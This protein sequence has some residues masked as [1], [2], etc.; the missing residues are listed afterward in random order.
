MNYRFVTIMMCISL[1]SACSAKSSPVHGLSELKQKYPSITKELDDVSPEQLDRLLL[2]DYIPFEV[3]EVDALTT[4]S[5]EETMI[6]LVYSNGDQNVHIMKLDDVATYRQRE[7][8]QVELSNGTRAK[9]STRQFGDQLTWTDHQEKSTYIIK[10]MSYMPTNSTSSNMEQL[11]RIANS[12]H[13]A[14]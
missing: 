2:P 5:Q 7:G 8:K 3:K 11:L 14:S 9:Y 1:M 12:M 4:T 10:L 6:E 13:T